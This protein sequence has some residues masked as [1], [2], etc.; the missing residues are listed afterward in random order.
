MKLDKRKQSFIYQQLANI[1]GALSN[2]HRLKMLGL[3]AQGEKSIDELAR[4]TSQSLAAASANV[5]VL[6]H[7]HLIHTDKRGRSMYCALAD[8]SVA[9]LWL[10]FRGVGEVVV[11][12]IREVMREEFDAD[13]RLSPLSPKDLQN[14]MARGRL[15]LVDLRP[16]REYEQGHLPKARS[17]P[18]DQLAGGVDHLPKSYPML[19]YCR[20]PICAAAI[21]GNRWLNEHQFR[22]QRLRFSV[23]EWADAGL[24]VESD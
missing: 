6:R 23:P 8:P 9:Q 3:L 18:L 15:T 11:P 14:R 7:S 24:P 22:S 13:E 12:E 2:P 10:R 16:T 5:K 20:G 4:L 17:I 19:V 1:G 21:A